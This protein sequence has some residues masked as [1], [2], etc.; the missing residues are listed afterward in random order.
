[1]GLSEEK[2]SILPF[3]CSPNRSANDANHTKPGDVPA[4]T[5]TASTGP[6]GAD[7]IKRFGQLFDETAG[8]A[9]GAGTAPRPIGLSNIST[10]SGGGAAGGAASGGAARMSGGM[11]VTGS[12][13]WTRPAAGRPSKLVVGVAGGSK[14]SAE[15]G[16][17]A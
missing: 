8:A 7:E 16:A 10:G 3:Q 4:G 2:S 17:Q 6:R 15:A 9:E 14:H 5:A 13:G 12:A 11:G 1:M